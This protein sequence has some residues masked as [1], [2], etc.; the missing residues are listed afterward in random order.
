M[1]AAPSNQFTSHGELLAKLPDFSSLAMAKSVLSALRVYN[2][3]RDLI[4]LASILSGLNT[5]AVLKDLPQSIKSPD[6]DFMTLLNIMNTILLVK[7][8]VR[9][10]QF[11]LQIVCEKKG[12]ASIAHIIRQAMKRYENLE[13]SFNI[14]IDF[15]QDA[16]NGSGKWEFIVKSLLAGYSDNVFVSMKELH[17]KTHRFARYNDTKD[18]AIL[19]LQ[20]TLTRPI[21]QAPISVV[22]ARDIRY[23]TAVRSTAVLSFVGA[24]KTSWIEYTI[25]RNIEISHEERNHLNGK[26]IWSFFKSTLSHWIDFLQNKPIVSLSG[27][28][29]TVINDEFHLR[30]QMVTTMK[31]E[32]EN[33][34]RQNTAAYTNLANNLESITKMTYIFN[35][36]KWRWE[37]QKQ[38]KITVTNNPAKK[39]CDIIVEGR[40][41]ENE[42]VKKEFDSFLG[43]L[44][45]AAVVRHP[46][47]GN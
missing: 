26:N 10:H 31:F 23:A 15:Y 45:K 28:T 2:C 47:A 38:V 32:L 12:L 1:E 42:N 18:I 25:K 34:C 46:N 33:N 21:S 22:L 36:M 24:I 27:T 13:K 29:G 5:T 3:G 41:S 35:P 14:S 6:G 8:S 30:K 39:T 40:H 11:N 44:Q 16:Q 43:W 20:S 37:A 17:E 19:D 4:R 9:N 7:E